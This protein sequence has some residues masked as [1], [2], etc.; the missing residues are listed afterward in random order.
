MI[1][2]FSDI[3]LQLSGQRALW[4]QVPSILRT[5]SVEFRGQ[6]IVF[7]TVF[8]EEP[9]DHDKQLLFDVGGY[10]VGDFPDTYTLDEI[11]LVVPEPEKAPRLKNLLYQRYEKSLGY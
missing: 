2:E 6:E 8:S 5:A 1:E 9:S 10:I 3:D 7:Q 11:H 4:G